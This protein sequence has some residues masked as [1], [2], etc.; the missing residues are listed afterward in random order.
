MIEEQSVEFE[1]EETLDCL[2]EQDGDSISDVYPDV[3]LNISR[4]TASVFQMKRKLERNPPMLDLTPPFQ[5]EFVWKTEQKCEL[6]E[7]II[8]G[9]PLPAF[10]VKENENGV[11]I[12]VDGKQRLSAL[13]DFIDG[14][15]KL[16]RLS[17]L[18]DRNNL[19][20]DQLS[21]IE[22]NKI[23]DYTLTIN[24][25]R[26]PTSDRVTFDL[27]DRVNRGGTKINHQEMRNALYQGT[28]THLIDAL[29]QTDSFLDA[30]ERS[31]SPKRMKDRYLV[32]RF[33]AFYLWFK[34]LSVDLD[35]D[36]P[37]EYKSNIEDFLGKTMSF[38]N[39]R[40]SNDPLILHLEQKFNDTMLAAA[41]YIVP[42]GGFR[43][44]AT[45]KNKR[46]INMAFFESFCCLM[47]ALKNLTPDSVAHAYGQLM[48]NQSYIGTLTYSIDSRSQ[49]QAR[50]DC[51]KQYLC[52]NDA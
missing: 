10:Y 43:L 38:L 9:I 2:S 19:S 41:Q 35:E 51:L 1:G 24:V 50:Y 5:R 13:F 25:I 40:S 34:H 11:Y 45:G 52:E 42:L 36:R 26:A 7:S 17:I 3:L 27:F 37:L 6:I 44:P 28:S 22:Q 30:T 29:A 8:M 12:V 15:F 46:P 20:F 31:I 23:E 21:L 32:L 49:I 16:N 39:A 47:S 33:L 18:K 48:S 4:E 14:K